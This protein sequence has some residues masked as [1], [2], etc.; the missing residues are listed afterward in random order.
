MKRRIPVTNQ[1]VEF[2]S[3]NEVGELG[4][5]KAHAGQTTGTVIMPRDLHREL[6]AEELNHTA[7]HSYIHH[8]ESQQ[9]TQWQLHTVCRQPY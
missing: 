3:F 6:L 5:G 8:L 2:Q 4:R 9:E 7:H 1:I